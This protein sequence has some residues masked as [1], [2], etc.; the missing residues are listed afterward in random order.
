MLS[1]FAPYTAEYLWTE[2][3]HETSVVDA[4]YPEYKEEYI[5]ENTFNYPI[6]FNGKTRFN[7]ELPLNISKEEV[8]QL[9]L[10]NEQTKKYLKDLKPKKFIFVEKK[11]VNIVV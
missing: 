8:E 11:I 1:P 6:S 4:P 10:S 9:V 3:G 2:L 5:I 7:L